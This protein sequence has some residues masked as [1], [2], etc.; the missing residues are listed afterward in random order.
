MQEK[1]L[2][3]LPIANFTYLMWSNL[4]DKGNKEGASFM[5]YFN[6]PKYCQTFYCNTTAPVEKRIEWLDAI[7]FNKVTKLDYASNKSKYLCEDHFADNCFCSTSKNHLTKFA[8][9]S[10]FNNNLILFIQHKKTSD[11]A[12]ALA[13]Y[14]RGLR[15]YSFL[16]KVTF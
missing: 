3:T 2:I 12:F 11:K 6:L 15:C 1:K 9:P 7:N 8:V 13:I 10:I 14:K 5:C 4:C 16:T